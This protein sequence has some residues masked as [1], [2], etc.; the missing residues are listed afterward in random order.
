MS[1]RPYLL[2]ATLVTVGASLVT[3]FDAGSFLT[4]FVLTKAV[5]STGL[6]VSIG[7][8]QSLTVLEGYPI[9][10]GRDYNIGGPATFYLAT[11]GATVSI[12]IMY[13][14]TDGAEG[15]SLPNLP[16]APVGLL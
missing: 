15:S 3:R 9:R 14:F 13:G 5:G 12:N 16:R 2:G 10:D 11:G 4:G 7:A 8:G 6:D 1:S